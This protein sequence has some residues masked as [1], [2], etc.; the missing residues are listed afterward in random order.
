MKQLLTASRQAAQ[1]TC[2][3][4]HF[5]SY[6]IGLRRI[7]TGLALRFGSA[8]HRGMEARWRGATYETAL[9]AAIPD[10]VDLDELAAETVAALLCGYYHH[11]GARDTLFSSISPEIE[12]HQDLPGSR[13]FRDAGKID[14]I[15][16][17][18]DGRSA[19]KEHK[20]TSDDIGPDS[21]YWMRLR[22]NPQLLQYVSAARQMGIQIETA[23]YDVARKPGIQPKQI[24]MLDDQ[25]RK[26]VLDSTGNRVMKK[27]GQPRESGD[28]EKGYVVQSRVE[29]PKEF[30][31]R[32]FQ[33]TLARPDFY[34]AR[35][36]VPILDQ[37][38]DEF[39]AQR[40]VVSR[41][42]L[43][44]RAQEKHQA[45]RSQ[46]WPRNIG[47]ACDWCE[48]AVF[49]LQNLSVDASNPPTGFRIGN[50]NPELKK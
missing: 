39:R 12:F 44:S 30:G 45:R 36:E 22:F 7:E 32:L 17:L 23:I 4:K 1:L 3:R 2:P 34:F 40:L 15:G 33:D 21:D 47:M 37:D 18:A 25:G 31:D 48:Y 26:V 10:G 24:P 42:I 5:W 29:T 8:W 16:V 28:A 13:S 35:R 43:A 27:D 11:Y 38:L 6:E 46:A 19:I 14:G 9:A 20:T 41:M 49:C 50:T